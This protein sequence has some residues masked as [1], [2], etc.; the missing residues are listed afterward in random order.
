[1]T[2]FTLAGSLEALTVV[3]IN[4]EHVFDS[5]GKK[6]NIPTTEVL[7]HTATSNFSKC[8]KLHNTTALIAILLP[9][10]L[11]KSVVIKGDTVAGGLLKKFATKILEQGSESTSDNSESES[12]SGFDEEDKNKDTNDKTTG[13]SATVHNVTDEISACCD[14]IPTF[15]QAVSVKAMQVATIPLLLRMDKH[16]RNWLLR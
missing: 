14:D 15:L 16:A 1:M 2:T 5:A 12:N 4:N 8:K 7:L 11:T 6:I 10:F 13:K 3:L 9:Q